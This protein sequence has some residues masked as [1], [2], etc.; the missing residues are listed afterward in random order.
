MAVACKASSHGGSG[1]HAMRVVIPDDYGGAVSTLTCFSDLAAHDVTVHRDGVTDLDL[2]AGR[3]AAAEALV[4][5]RERTRI[6]RDLLGRLPA[7]RLIAQTGRGIPHIDVDAC[8]ERGVLV[9]TGEGSPV[10]PAELTWALVLAALRHIPREAAAL[11][12]GRWQTGLGS[13][14][15]GKTIGIYG[16]GSIGALVAR[17]AQAFGM[18]VLASGRTR[19]AERAAADG[20][21]VTP[22][23]ALFRDADVLSLHLKL[24]DETR[25]I[26]TAADL[27]SM[28][29]TALLVNTARA[30]LIEHG[31]LAAALA[32]GRPGYAAVDVF[33]DEPVPPDDPLPRLDNVLCTPHIGYVTRESYEHYFGQAF[34]QVN[35]FAA[36]TPTGVVNPEALEVGRR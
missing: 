36:G 34:A 9:C 8:S 35:A 7:L 30:G 17:Y 10:A 26:V 29:P 1:I 16:Y 24:T 23:E 13:D 31:A 22:P 15:D 19:S 32:R 3:F 20:V 21:E 6:D 5:I 18:R 2:L 4:L 27:A 25:A 14:L 33:D 11:A 12:A 28:K